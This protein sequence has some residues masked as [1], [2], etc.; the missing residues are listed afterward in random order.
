MDTFTLIE[1]A[2]CVT[3]CRGV[4]RQTQLYRRGKR[5]YAKHAG[6]FARIGEKWG[7]SW[8]TSVPNLKV[9]DFTA[10]FH[11]MAGA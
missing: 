4:Y 5:I 1:D 7:A 10:D 9:V 6:G 11:H 8:P 2:E 3:Y